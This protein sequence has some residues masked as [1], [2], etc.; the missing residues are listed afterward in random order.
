[1]H[2]INPSKH[3]EIVQLVR[4]R[5]CSANNRSS[6]L[7][8]SA[9][10]IAHEFSMSTLNAWSSGVTTFNEINAYR[11][12]I[13]SRSF[14]SARPRS[15]SRH[16]SVEIQ[17]KLKIYIKCVKILWWSFMYEG[18]LTHFH[19]Y[20][21]LV[22]ARLRFRNTFE[23]LP[24]RIFYLYE[25]WTSVWWLMTMLLTVALDRYALIFIYTY[26]QKFVERL[27]SRC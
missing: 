25:Q 21:A 1:M 10:L 8:A 13:A 26:K 4:R 20:N 11:A 12:F 16:E 6:S 18:L 22:T 9:I 5:F 14:S 2:S 15:A 27:C 24:K 23:W 7:W 19:G 3:F 17:F